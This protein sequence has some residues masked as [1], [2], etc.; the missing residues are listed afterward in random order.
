MAIGGGI[1]LGKFKF[2]GPGSYITSGSISDTSYS[3]TVSFSV[4]ISSGSV[5]IV[6]NEVSSSNPSYPLPLRVSSAGTTLNL[7]LIADN[8]GGWS[9]H[10]FV[11][12]ATVGGGNAAVLTKQAEFWNN[13]ANN[14][15]TYTTSW[16]LTDIASG[17]A[18]PIPD[19][20]NAQR[21]GIILRGDTGI[22]RVTAISV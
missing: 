21:Y 4:S 11:S 20:T 9:G 1:N 6:I 8:S 12:S 16:R 10:T 22:W 13:T 2:S 19:P 15:S 7:L 14:S 5:V 3:F 17:V 18:P